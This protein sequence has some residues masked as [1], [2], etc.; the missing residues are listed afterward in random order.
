MNFSFE[1]TSIYQFD[2]NIHKDMALAA[3]KV[4]E[5]QSWWLGERMIPL[6]LFSRDVDKDSL[7]ALA[8]G[9]KASRVDPAMKQPQEPR[10]PEFPILKKTKMPKDFVGPQ[11][12]TLF[13]LVEDDV[14]W[15]RLLPNEWASDPAFLASKEIV[16]SFH[17]VNDIADY[18]K[19]RNCIHLY[20]SLSLFLLSSSSRPT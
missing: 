2:L 17:G 5:R 9:L 11:S 12:W 1:I 6:A 3:I 19:V 7:S 15:L 14:K 16:S 4:L 8:A 10:K 18:F 13:D 20:V